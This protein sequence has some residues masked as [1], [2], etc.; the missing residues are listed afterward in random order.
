MCAKSFFRLPLLVAACALPPLAACDILSSDDTPPETGEITLAIIHELVNYHS[1]AFVWSSTFTDS[2]TL[3]YR[4]NIAHS[5]TQQTQNVPQSWRFEL[6]RESAMY[7]LPFTGLQADTM[8][9]LWVTAYRR[10]AGFQI[11]GESDR[12]ALAT[13]VSPYALISR[14]PRDVSGL[15]AAV[16]DDRIYVVW[17]DQVLERYDPISEEWTELPSVP[18]AHEDFGLAAVGATLYVIGGI[19]SSDVDAFNTTTG[20]WETRPPIPSGISVRTAVALSGAVYTFASSGQVTESRPWSEYPTQRQM[21]VYQPLTRTWSSRAERPGQDVLGPVVAAAG[22]MY[23]LGSYAA[24]DVDYNFAT[25]SVSDSVHVYDPA[26]DQWETLATG[27]DGRAGFHA[28]AADGAVYLVGGVIAAGGA[29]E[30]WSIPPTVQ[31]DPATETWRIRTI[32]GAPLGFGADGALVHVGSTMYFLNGANRW[33]GI[34][35]TYAP[36]I[37]DC[38]FDV[39]TWDDTTPYGIAYTTTVAKPAA[40]DGVALGRIRMGAPRRR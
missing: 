2:I 21:M 31:F 14:E 36:A 38:G 13:C 17:P 8:H 9:Y 29:P 3:R 4:L 40:A 30:V 7:V 24:G 39:M 15:R 27:T 16:I 33:P 37:D 23:L 22:K 25:L 19:G 5:D 11:V 10:E 26:V 34:V 32:P 28:V 20:A 12:V 1:A 35:G 6:P 18:H